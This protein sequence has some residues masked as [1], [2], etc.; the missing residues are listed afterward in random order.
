MK[1]LFYYHFNKAPITG[2]TLCRR[3]KS[4]AQAEDSSAATHFQS[5]LIS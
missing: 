4:K 3:Q 5:T 1:I 2:G